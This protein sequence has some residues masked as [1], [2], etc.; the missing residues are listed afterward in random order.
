MSFSSGAVAE[1]QKV[2]TFSM[3]ANVR[4]ASGM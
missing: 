4:F 3:A 2:I 1:T